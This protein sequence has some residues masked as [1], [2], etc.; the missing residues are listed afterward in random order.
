VTVR[1]WRFPRGT[2]ALRPDQVRGFQ[3]RRLLDAFV[4]VCAQRGYGATTTTL[5]AA[6]AGVS[7][8]SYYQV[9][10]DKQECMLAAC[11]EQGERFADA[12]SVAW[13]SQR[14][15]APALAA[16]LDA[17]LRLAAAE[18]AA[19]RLLWIEAR[20]A[21]G[22]AGA[23][24]EQL[25]DR[26][27]AALRGVRPPAVAEPPVAA[28]RFVV[29]SLLSGLLAAEPRRREQLAP[30]LAVLAGALLGG[31]G[32][33]G[34]TAALTGHLPPITAHPPSHAPR[35]PQG[36]A[37]PTAPED[38]QRERLFDALLDLLAEHPYGRVTVA[39]IAERA[40]VAHRTFTAYFA[41]KDACALAAYRAHSGR[42]ATELAAAWA[43]PDSLSARVGAATDAALRFAA[44]HPDAA[45]FL[46]EGV[47]A[48]GPDGLA[49]QSA[50]LAALAA[51][52]REARPDA[53]T[54][55]AA[56]EEV[57]IAGVTWVLAERL[58]A[59]ALDPDRLP[60]LS[61]QFTAVLLAPYGLAAAA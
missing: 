43:R 35:I 61:V 48:V 40:G 31:G 5:V 8:A 21:G 46:A 59:R 42:L 10:A 44:Q 47:L 55:P 49:L 45:L 24:R 14:G 52:L 37:G 50:S 60:Q 26:L 11:R 32:A 57:R 7:T 33:D 58:R 20:V 2:G 41:G 28:E 30:D 1:G 18:P 6:E 12:L 17:G 29:D 19:A 15:R 34:A 25:L 13:R 51:A 54:V 39:Q 9:F 38:V 23:L 4:A 22:A 3:R 36:P 27:A 53:A 16:A 56:T